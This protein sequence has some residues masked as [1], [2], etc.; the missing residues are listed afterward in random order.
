MTQAAYCSQ[1]GTNVYVTPDGRCPN[2]HG[3][4][5]LS[6]F[7][8]TGEG[9]AP[10]PEAPPA[11]TPPAYTPAPAGAP[12][13][14]IG[15][16]PQKKSKAGLI[17]AIVLAILVLC[18]V[19]VGVTMC[20]LGNAAEDAIQEIEDSTGVTVDTD[21]EEPADEAEEPAESDSQPPASVDDSGMGPDTTPPLS[22]GVTR[23]VL[24]W[25]EVSDLD[26]EIWTSDGQS[27]ITRALTENGNDV[28]D[29]TS[30][31]EYFDFTGEYGSG[32]YVVSIYYVA[33]NEGPNS[34][35]AKVIVYK[36]D[37]TTET[38]TAEI[39]WDPGLDQWHAF[40]IDADTG[41]IV[42]IDEFIDIETTE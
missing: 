37:G 15:A 41:S 33:T 34:T 17:I 28:M 36:A 16:P 19:G 6:N 38:R 11:Y 5:F 23:V 22:G 26:L 35:T 7:Y 18:G 14:P 25:D 27:L 8:E 13:G 29:G 40:R 30:G 2:G 42:D 20:A 21:T 39:R 1:C 32:E 12:G 31:R 9:G 3:P 4:E 10:A 24:G